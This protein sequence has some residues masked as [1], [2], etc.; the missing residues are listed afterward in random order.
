MS[1]SDSDDQLPREAEQLATNFN[2]R[3][4]AANLP[5][6]GVRKTLPTTYAIVT[7]VAGRVSPGRDS[8]S[9]H[10]DGYLLTEPKKIGM[11]EVVHKNSNPQFTVT[12]PVKYE[13]GA[14]RYFMIQIY[15]VVGANKNDE[16]IGT[17]VCEIGDI[18]GSKSRIKAKR[19]PNGGVVFCRLEPGQTEEHYS[20]FRFQFEACDLVPRHRTLRS[21]HLSSNYEIDTFVQISKCTT[22]TTPHFWVTVYRSAPVLNSVNPKWDVGEVDVHSVCN[23]DYDLPLRLAVFQRGL[24]GSDEMVGVFDTTLREM[25][26]TQRDAYRPEA[27]VHASGYQLRRS[28]I[29]NKAAGRLKVPFAQVINHFELD[30][31]SIFTDIPPALSGSSTDRSD[32]FVV[33]MS[34]LPVP[35]AAP[36]N[37]RDYIESGWAL[38]FCVAIDFTSSN[39][40]PRIP[41]TLH[42]LSEGVVN[43]YEET[44]VSIGRAMEPYTQ[45]RGSAVWGFGCKYGGQVRHLFQCGPNPEV[46]GVTEIVEAYKDVF[47][48]DLIM[49]GPTVFE[50]VVKSAAFRAR[51]YQLASERRYC[52]LLV[53]TDGI[54]QEPQETQRLLDVYGV[55]PLSVIFVGV[56]R[57]DFYSLRTICETHPNASG[58]GRNNRTFCEF[59][60]HQHDPSSL[61]RSA[62][63]MIPEQLVQY[64][65]QSN[66][67]P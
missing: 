56:G 16:P 35:I 39:G 30:D 26:D 36:G 53:V 25:L 14:E 34:K 28:L 58:Q 31:F 24:G 50:S 6:V 7:S 54:C 44:I 4:H 21:L 38:D 2:L 10:Q 47:N 17:S 45:S 55:L 18:L 29:K 11:T 22:H 64:M 57:A 13:Y 3:I 5:R 62:L 19:L 20:M 60:Q 51:N 23:G 52:V 1:D 43:D 61:G 65:Q 66:I 67:S 37:F 9:G 42:D 63:N 46:F 48:T 33:D 41:G 32:P 59:R 8:F 40:D 15:R 12:V 49:S 27:E